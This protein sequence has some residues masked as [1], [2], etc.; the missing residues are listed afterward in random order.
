MRRLGRHNEAAA[1]LC[2]V[3]SRGGDSSNLTEQIDT[4]YTKIILERL[5]EQAK[6][7]VMQK[8]GYQVAYGPFKGLKLSKKQWWGNDFTTKILG[9]YERDVVDELVSLLGERE[10]SVFVD[11]GA[12][13]G[14]YAVGVAHAKLAQIVFAFEISQKGREVIQE[15]A[16]ANSCLP[17]LRIHGEADLYALKS[18]IETHDSV[19]ALIDIEGAE[20]ELLTDEMLSLLKGSKLIVELHPHLIPSGDE[21]EEALISRAAKYFKVSK[22]YKSA[23][24]PNQFSELNDLSDDIRLIAFS[25]DRM[26]NPKWLVLE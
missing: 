18:I 17:K 5:K 7:A 23:Y 26:R 13:D 16:T 12:A 10:N 14:Y 22:L 2:P 15:T 4:V 1:A 3:R 25:E 24:D 9:Q 19:V 6:H 11:I 8:T 20:Y 21:F